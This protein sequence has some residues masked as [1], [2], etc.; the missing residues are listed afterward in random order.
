MS[1][2]LNENNFDRAIDEISKS[3]TMQERTF[4]NNTGMGAF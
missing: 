2:I 4:V 3:W 1:E